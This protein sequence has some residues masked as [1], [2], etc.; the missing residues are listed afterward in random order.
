[1]AKI[2][3]VMSPLATKQKQLRV[4]AYARVSSGKDAMLHSLSAQ[5]SYYSGF[6]QNHPG[7]AFAGIY[8]DEAKTGTKDTRPEFQRLLQ[9]CRDG[10]IDMIVTK[11]ISR[12]SRNTVTL[13]ETTRELKAL[14]ITVFFQKEGLYSDRGQGELVLTL[15]AAV[16]QEESRAVS[17]NCKWRIRSRFKKGELAGLSFM[18]GYRIKKGSV[19]IEPEE[20]RVVSWIF[21]AYLSHVGCEAI[22]QTLREQQVPTLQGGDWT[23][24]RVMRMLK[25]E[26]YAGNAL[27]QKRY[28]TDHITKKQVSNSG[29]LPRYFAQGT[30]PA[31]ISDEVFQQTQQLIE[32]NRVKN[33]IVLKPPARYPLSGKILCGYCGKQFS[34]VTRNGIPKWQCATYLRKGRGACHAKQIPEETLFA[35]ACNVTGMD[36]FDAEIFNQLILRIQVTE[37][38]AVRFIFRNGQQVDAVWQ[39]RSRRDSWTDEMK[40]E[41]REKMILKGKR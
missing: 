32:E 25:N 12:F 26:K 36:V 11:A 40:Q 29:Q 10:K 27:L 22:A 7:W 18:Y 24:N 37:P 34:R 23:S 19:I 31:I 8:A 13:L 35:L 14:G 2:Y 30:H 39:D 9:D 3:K 5:I 20:A 21:Y 4:A 33:N 41:A 1:M 17:D 6:I 28:V 38:N 15:L 16:A